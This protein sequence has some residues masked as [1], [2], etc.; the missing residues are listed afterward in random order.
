[1]ITTLK[2]PVMKKAQKLFRLDLA[3]GN[4]KQADFVGV[5]LIKDGT[6]ADVQHDLSK[7][8]WPFEDNSVDE[9]FCSHFLEHIPHGDS[10]ND[11]L[12]DF[13]N[14]VWRIMKPGARARFV[15]PYYASVRSIQ[16]PTHHRAIGE[17][18]FL[19]FN[20]EWRKVNRLEHYPIKANF[21]IEK[22]DHAVSE[23]YVGKSQE[24]VQFAAAHYWNVVNDIAVTLIKKEK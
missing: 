8:P 22:I 24:A 14:E 21:D 9:I 18:T 6:E 13:F 5:D 19:Y 7:Y 4:N 2:K 10:Y 3:C 1:M 16:D 12:F 23:E 15:V 17:P 11:G 20:A